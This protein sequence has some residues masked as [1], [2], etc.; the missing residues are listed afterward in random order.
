MAINNYFVEYFCEFEMINEVGLCGWVD[1][2]KMSSNLSDYVNGLMGYS[3][4]STQIRLPLTWSLEVKGGSRQ[5]SP[6]YL[7]SSCLHTHHPNLLHPS[8]LSSP[9]F[10]VITYI[11][12]CRTA[13]WL[14]GP[15]LIMAS[16]GVCLVI[17][18]YQTCLTTAQED[19][20]QTD[21]LQSVQIWP[22][23]MKLR[24]GVL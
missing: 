14:M 11:S 21:G 8:S 1:G 15:L 10:P 2:W 24:G 17:R 16:G 20:G 13:V 6:R 12:A 5:Y 7:V 22:Q 4:L 9:I 18:C 23:I 3:P 19:P